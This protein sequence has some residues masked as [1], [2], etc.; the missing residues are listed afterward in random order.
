MDLTIGQ[1][2]HSNKLQESFPY[3]QNIE[4]ASDYLEQL[5]I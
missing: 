1:K 4:H 3:C 5:I 2:E